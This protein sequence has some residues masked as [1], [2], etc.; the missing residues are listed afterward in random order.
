[1]KLLIVDNDVQTCRQ[2][3]AV[4]KN[5]Y[6]IQIARTGREALELLKN[7][8]VDGIIAEM[9]LPE[10]DGFQLWWALKQDKT[11]KNIPFI[12]IDTDTEYKSFFF[13][14]RVSILKKSQIKSDILNRLQ[15]MLHPP[16]PQLLVN[17][18]APQKQYKSLFENAPIGIYRTTP[19]G[20]T[21]MANPTLVRMLGYSSFEELAQKN[22]EEEGPCAGYPR[23]VVKELLARDGQI[24]GLESTWTRRDGTTVF[25]RE[26]A[27]A[28]RD[29]TGG[30]L[31]YE[32]TI[33]DITK[34]K[35]A[36]EQLQKNE[37]RFRALV[38]NSSDIIYVLDSQ[39]I[40]QYVSP[41]VQQIL[42][43]YED[44]SPDDRL[45]VMDF[46]HPDDVA[47]AAAMLAALKENPDKTMAFEVRIR[48]INKSYKWMEVWGKNLLDDPAVLGIVLNVR[49][50]TGRKQAEEELKESEEQYRTIV[51]LSPLGIVTTDI[52]GVVNSCNTAFLTLTGFEKGDIVDRHFTRTPIVR[53]RDIPR[54]LKMFSSAVRK[55]KQFSSEFTWVHKDGST[56]IGEASINPMRKKGNLTG[57]QAIV[58]DITEKK[59]SEEQLRESEQKYR[60]IV[61]LSP[62]GIITVDMKGVITSCNTAFSRLTGFDKKDIV[63]KHFTQVPTGRARDIPHYFHIFGTLLMGKIPKPF[64]FKWQHKDG[65][66]R[67]GEVYFSRMKKGRKTTGIQV[68]LQDI[69]ERKKTEEKLRHS[70][71]KYRTLVENLHVGVYRATAGKHG[72]FID[73]NQEFVQMLGYKDKEELMKLPISDMYVNLGD[74]EKFS[75]KIS[76]RGFVKNEELHLKR[77]DGTPVIISDTATTVYDTDGTILYFDGISEDVT[78]RKRVEEELKKY[79]HHLEDLVEERAAELKKTNEQLQKE[80][81][82]RIS[83]E[84]L[85]AAEKE[86]LSVTLRSIGDGVIT[87]DIEGTIV[88]INKVAEM[89]TG[90][91]QEEAVGKPLKEVFHIINEKT[92]IPCENPVEKVLNRG[93]VVGLGNNTVLVAKDG[94]EKVI[95]DSGAPI[96]DKNSRTI[97]VVLVFRDITEK[98]KLEQRVL[99]TQ[100]LESL[101]ILAGGIAHDFNNIL[102]A[103]LNNVTL[104]KMYAADNKIQAK[105]I[106]VEKAS[107][108][109]RNLTQQLLTFSKGGKPIKKTISI[110]RLVRDSVSFALRGSNVRCHFYMK[111]DVWPVD[112]DEGQI[113]QVINNLIINADQ[114][115]PDGGIVRVYAENV[116]I[117][118]EDEL[119]LDPGNYI[120]ITI[121]DEGVGIAEKYVPKIFDPYFTTKQKGSGLGLATCYSIIKRHNG[122][123]DVESEVGVGTIF[124]MWLPTSVKKGI[125]KQPETAMAAG[126]GNVLLMDDEEIVLEAA[127]EV[128]QY[129][130]YTVTTAKDG[131]EALEL[132]TKAL[133]TDPFDVVI[134]DLTIPGGMGGKEAIQELL[135]LDPGITAIVSSGYSNDPVMANYKKY[136]FKGVVT[137][138]YTIEE[139]S[140]T[141][142]ETLKDS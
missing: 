67:L 138:P 30:V 1:M 26:N 119:P 20:R 93:T 103:I 98:R 110:T 61:E 135:M 120:K 13:N 109:A 106:K 39:G 142:S 42:G 131:K 29:S 136:G 53:M 4:L 82:D 59:Q 122:H 107:L 54:F 49:N 88:L 31:Y 44:I 130:G 15:D 32:G 47:A 121:A 85:L 91:T 28:V 65:S 73:V 74:R 113:S 5:Q 86:Q 95:A 105:L 35:H 40:I 2:L 43:Y 80:I 111:D 134:M 23:S 71:E 33:E 76:S 9:V 25:F 123:I 14:L 72:S 56:R 125:E 101:G 11:L 52:K 63:G 62:F 58:R 94:T 84:E 27:K 21:V 66:T 83:A 100:K 37:N 118:P 51:E 41:N 60:N 132:Y 68:L 12:F 140:T 24:I 6:Q 127:S 34:R 22:L 112:V 137:K 124:Y 81:Y 115:M 79:R 97:G 16:H 7:E 10:M 133:T 38:R 89:L 96:L 102:T 57:I 3:E 129:L 75:K 8:H 108:Q 126:R 104:A 50:I 128:L 36:E 48:D 46:V 69:T 87:T 19:D 55:K 99:R 117:T 116:V 77:K 78:E 92:R 90:Y 139:L 114:A 45:R 18:D 70:E 141:L 17:E 64:E